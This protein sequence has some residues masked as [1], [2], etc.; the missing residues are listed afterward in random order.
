MLSSRLVAVVLATASVP[1]VA[2]AQLAWQ[3]RAGGPIPSARHESALAYDPSGGGLVLFGGSSNGGELNDTWRWSG[4]VWQQ[5]APATS[6]APR[7]GPRLATDTERGVVVLFGGMTFSGPFPFTTALGDTWEWNGTNWVQRF[8]ATNPPARF[9]HALA[10]DVARGV[11]V[12]QGGSTG[13]SYLSDTWEWNGVDWAPRPTPPVPPTMNHSMTYDTARGVLVFANSI[14]SA[15]QGTWEWNGATWVPRGPCP[16]G[17]GARIAYDTARER[18][19]WYGGAD[20]N[21]VALPVGVW[22]W[23]GQAWTQRATAV[24]P[25]PRFWHV[26]AY[27]PAAAELVAFGGRDDAQPSL[28]QRKNDTWTLAPM[29]PATA[30]P[31]GTGCAGSAGVLELD[32]ADRPWLGATLTIRWSNV[33][34]GT[35]ALLALG[36]SRQDWLGVP[37]P[38]PLASIGMPG[39]TLLASLDV[40]LALPV[41]ASVLQQQVPLPNVPAVLGMELFAQG[42]DLDAGANPAGITASNGLALRLGAL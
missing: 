35:V 4:G 10:Y 37:L 28:Q 22:E 14:L 13:P 41:P 8:P 2:L 21:G 33:A 5:L 17:F 26:F 25:P 42:F 23:N 29:F 34:P 12:L 38:L 31:F 3:L 40:G 32:T 19:V 7:Y 15:S 18:V 39:C 9:G 24:S 1:T 36:G 6:P 30:I 27:E 16:Q 20:G 11:T